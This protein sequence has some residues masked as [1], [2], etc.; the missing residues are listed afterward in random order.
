MFQFCHCCP[1][2]FIDCHVFFQFLSL[3]ADEFLPKY[4]KMAALSH[5]EYL[6]QVERNPQV[7]CGRRVLASIIMKKE[8]KK[9]RKDLMKVVSMG[10]GE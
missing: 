5:L 4:P 1:R 6:K 7:F 8:Q 3:L 9:G 10:M 2:F